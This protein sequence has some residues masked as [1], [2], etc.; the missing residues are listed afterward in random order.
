LRGDGR[1]GAA[2]I[3]VKAGLVA[4]RAD[5]D[6]LVEPLLGKRAAGKPKQPASTSAAVN[7]F[8]SPP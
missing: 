8:I 3:L 2:D 6:D 7:R 1:A 5:L 4:E